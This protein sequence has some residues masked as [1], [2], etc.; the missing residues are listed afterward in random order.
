MNPKQADAVVIG[1]GIVGCA[2]AYNLTRSGLRP[3]VVDRGGVAGGTSGSC[4]GHLMMLADSQEMYRLSARSLALWKQFHAEVGGFELRDCGCLWLGESDADVPLLEDIAAKIRGF[5]GSGR[6]VEP[7]E[8]RRM[9]P[10]LADDLVGAFFCPDDGILFP[11][12][13]AAALMGAAQDGGARTSYHTT[14]R[15]LHC[16][17]DSAVSAVETDR[18]IIETGIVVN[19]AGV[20][21]PEVAELFGLPRIPIFPR[22]GDLAITM[23]QDLPVT[24]QMVEVAYLRSA[25]GKVIDPE[26]DE[27]DPGTY[28]LNLQPQGNGTVLI[29]S[30]RQFGGFDKRVNLA[31]L[32]QSLARA[33]RFVP[34]LADLQIV[35]TWAGL[36]PYTKDKMPVIGPVESVPGLFVAGGHEGLGITLSTGTAEL[37][38]QAV[39]GQPLAQPLEP[40]SPV[41]F[42]EVVRGG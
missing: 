27:P 41:R 12:Q 9:E 42:T 22:R 19:A 31:L 32:Q 23:P 6:I 36:R 26:S 29:G 25:V 17:S 39:T 11:M 3:V 28:A 40:F 18:G 24:T 5:G 10:E 15:G 2:I 14:V 35:R 33:C 16:G 34:A 7:T 21:L 30:T 20:W 13:A 8:L 1:A 37:I 38:A 4:M